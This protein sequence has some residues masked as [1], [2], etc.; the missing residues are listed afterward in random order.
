MRR[1]GGRPR[2]NLERMQRDRDIR[3]HRDG[4]GE[5]TICQDKRDTKESLQRG[6]AQQGWDL[7]YRTYSRTRSIT[8][9]TYPNHQNNPHLGS[10]ELLAK[11][12]LK[13]ALARRSA[14]GAVSG[15]GSTFVL[16]VLLKREEADEESKDSSFAF[17]RA[18]RERDERL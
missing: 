1:I 2:D 13:V 9:F 14:L 6:A 4:R 10:Q 3:D 7:H 8:S 12:G 18:E 15:E 11:P 5:N 16:G 17:V